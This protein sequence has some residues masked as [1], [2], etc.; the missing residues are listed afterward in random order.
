MSKIVRATIAAAIMFAA[1]LALTGCPGGVGM[2]PGTT[3]I[4]GTGTALPGTTPGGGTTAPVATGPTSGCAQAA[5][6]SPA[7]TGKASLG[8]YAGQLLPSGYNAAY[9]SESEVTARFR[10]AEVGDAGIWACM[11]KFYNGA[12]KTYDARK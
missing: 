7:D 12:M 9:N 6:S 5:P 2:I 10:E 11:R 3:T 8:G 4:P 1:P